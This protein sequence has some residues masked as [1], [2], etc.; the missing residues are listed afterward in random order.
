[1]PTTDVTI[2]NNYSIPLYPQTYQP[3]SDIMLSK[4]DERVDF[5]L[6][7][8][9]ESIY[10]NNDVIEGV[11]RHC[12]TAVSSFRSPINSPFVLADRLRFENNS[13]HQS[14]REFLTAG[15][16]KG[17]E[18]ILSKVPVIAAHMAQVSK[19]KGNTLPSV[20]LTRLYQERIM[21]AIDNYIQQHGQKG[22][23]A[24]QFDRTLKLLPYLDT[25]NQTNPIVSGLWQFC[26]LNRQK[27]ESI[28]DRDEALFLCTTC[29]KAYSF[30]SPHFKRDKEVAMA[31]LTAPY[32]YQVTE[33]GNGCLELS[34]VHED[35]QTDKEVIL[36]CLKQP[37]TGFSIRSVSEPLKYDIDIIRA[38]LASSMENLK[39]LD[40]EHV[41]V[42]RVIKEL[43]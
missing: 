8:F 7:N 2:S 16:D 23:E 4:L 11:G 41:N 40:K 36:A 34:Y 17:T 1:M 42:Q 39:Y 22:H 31:A 21:S 12:G 13:F 15:S 3:L 38:S 9:S 33:A 27:I 37:Y 25:V 35:L 5:Y 43:S 18:Y 19:E 29:P 30:L 32:I 10:T 26:S 14:A 24:N 20:M 28:N 6:R